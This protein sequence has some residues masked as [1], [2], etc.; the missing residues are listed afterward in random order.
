[1]MRSSTNCTPRQLLLSTRCLSHGDDARCN[2]RPR[3]AGFDSSSTAAVSK[4]E[5]VHRERCA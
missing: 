3:A 5:R 2:S 1:M 4:M